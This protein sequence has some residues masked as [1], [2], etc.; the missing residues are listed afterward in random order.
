[1]I[2]IQLDKSPLKRNNIVGIPIQ[3]Y[4]YAGKG[5]EVGGGG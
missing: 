1:M 3:G 5:V 2:I 4:V